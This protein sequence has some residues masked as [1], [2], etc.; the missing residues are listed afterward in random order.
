MEDLYESRKEKQYQMDCDTYGNHMIVSQYEK[1][2]EMKDEAIA[3]LKDYKTIV[4]M[5]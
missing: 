4:L 1:E 5:K 3:Y 2:L